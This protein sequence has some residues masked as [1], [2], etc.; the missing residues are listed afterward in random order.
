M[1]GSDKAG[2]VVHWV[3]VR[4]MVIAW[5]LTMPAAGVMGALAYGGVASFSNPTVGVA[6]VGAVAAAIL[7][8]DL[9]R[10][11]PGQ[12][13]RRQCDRA[14]PGRADRSAG[15]GNRMIVGSL[16]DYLPF[17][18][19]AKILVVCLVVAVIAPSAVSVGVIGLDRR[20]HAE[21]SHDERRLGSGARS[22]SRSQCSRP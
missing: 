18:D 7:I 9:P 13:H 5:V 16:S 6:V 22:S 20:A 14:R 8:G 3:V 21:E 12:R 19:L 10:G 11:A 1:P 15:G 4:N 17:D 2:G